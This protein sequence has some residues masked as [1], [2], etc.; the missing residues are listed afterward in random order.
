MNDKQ[1]SPN[2][3][4]IL[5]LGVLG[6]FMC[7]LGIAAWI[8]GHQE[9]K[10]FPEDS[11]V[12]TGKILGMIMTLFNVVGTLL[13]VLI[14]GGVM[15]FAADQLDDLDLEIPDSPPAQEEVMEPENI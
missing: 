14:F 10:K 13:I 3:T 7:P 9:Q 11:N 15:F 1:Q 4:A 2:G 6:F 12:K 8:W 5:V